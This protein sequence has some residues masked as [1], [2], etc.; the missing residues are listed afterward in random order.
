[1]ICSCLLYTSGSARETFNWEDM[2]DIDI[3]LP[4]I[5]IQQKHVDVY[6]AMLENQK[7]YM[8][9]HDH[10]VSDSSSALC[11]QH[12]KWPAQTYVSDRWRNCSG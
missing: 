3:E 8:F 4:N 12:T 1:M 6:N 9:C 2:C 11:R 7:S 10:S 5:E